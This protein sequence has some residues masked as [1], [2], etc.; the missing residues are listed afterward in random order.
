[1]PTKDHIDQLV[2]QIKPPRSGV[3]QKVISVL[4]NP[5][6]MIKLTKDAKGNIKKV[7]SK[8]RHRSSY[9]R[10]SRKRSFRLYATLNKSAKINHRWIPLN[11]KI[12]GYTLKNVT[13]QFVTLQKGTAKPIKVFLNTKNKNIKLMTK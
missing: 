4:K 5:F 3:S 10:S 8:I 1:M 12:S 13:K 11:G 7:T 2:E 9:S 6:I